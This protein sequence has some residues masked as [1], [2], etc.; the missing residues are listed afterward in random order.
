M[1]YH[2]ALFVIPGFDEEVVEA[3]CSRLATRLWE[4]QIF[5]LATLATKHTL[6]RCGAAQGE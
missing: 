6:P 1:F 2:P 3:G 5:D 4:T